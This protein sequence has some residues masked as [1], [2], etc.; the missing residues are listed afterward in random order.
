[1]DKEKIFGVFGLGAFGMEICRVLAEKGAEVVAVDKDQQTIEKIKNIVTQAVLMDSADEEAL[2]NAGLQDVDVAIVAIG[3]NI[4][5]SI[6][7]TII[8]KNMGVPYIIARA[9]S[10]I[11]AQVLKQIGATEVI[12]IQIEQGRRLANRVS[13]HGV[14]DVIPISDNQLLVEVRVPSDFVGRSLSDLDLRKKLNINIISVKRTKT[15]IDDMGNPRRE[16][17]V[18]SPKPMDIFNVNDILVILGEQ[19]DIDKLKEI[20]K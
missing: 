10:N 7:T 4:D 6:L 18:F 16:E 14:M 8:L 2:K 13:L 1:M 3:D 17:S 12:N 5:A 9:V 15:E 20:I 11:H 19:G